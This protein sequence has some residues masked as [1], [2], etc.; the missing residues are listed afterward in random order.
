MFSLRKRLNLSF[1]LIL[2]F[3]IS[4]DSYLVKVTPF[5]HFLLLSSSFL[6]FIKTLETMCQQHFALCIRSFVIPI[7]STRLYL[8]SGIGCSQVNMLNIY[9]VSQSS[10]LF[11][12]VLHLMSLR[13]L[14]SCW[15]PYCFP[16]ISIFN[17][18]ESFSPSSLSFLLLPISWW[19][20]FL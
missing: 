7:S 5:I 8:W 18:T 11:F 16:V 3:A 14:R 19:L 2:F 13:F 10:W 17:F 12:F 15:I 4:L 6:F 20:H 1:F 9:F